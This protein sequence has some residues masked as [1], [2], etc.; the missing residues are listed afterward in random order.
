MSNQARSIIVTGGAGFIG[1]HL[2]RRLLA[3]GH[4]VLN[5]DKLTYAGNLRSLA[6]VSGHPS[7]SFLRA[8]IADAPAIHGAFS[9][10]RPDLIFHLAAESHVDR[11]ITGPMAFIGTNVTGTAVLLQAAL[12]TW[13]RHPR[14]EGFRFIHVST[15]EVFGALGD[16]GVFT[17]NS[18]YQ[19]RSPYSAS[20]AASDHLV[21]AWGETYGLPFIVTNSSNNYGPCQHPEKLIPLA[22]TRALGG[23]PIPIYGNGTQVRDWLHVLDHCDALVRV[24]A[25]G[26]NHDTY[27][28]GGG[29]ERRNL[30]LVR[31]LCGILD[32]LAP[33][34]AGGS[35][36]D[37]IT[38]VADRPGHD[39]RYALDA[40]K[41]SAHTGW[42]PEITR[43]EG[44]F[45]TV[46][47]YLANLK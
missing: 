6:D 27:L 7:Y 11:S 41:V 43:S 13:Q 12:E 47:W 28:I 42:E 15:D 17:E 37:Q 24:A 3:D 23:E 1:S 2:V 25:H 38:F 29:N 16:E 46:E 31:E 10:F 9:S 30:D 20:K 44:F 39:F 21:R 32:R 14:P 8:D 36:A 26:R 19:P 22:V 35:Y 4:R 45:S 18:P 33:K 40:A 34:P 5:I